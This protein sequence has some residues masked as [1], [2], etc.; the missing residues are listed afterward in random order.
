VEHDVTMFD[1]ITREGDTPETAPTGHVGGGG[2]SFSNRRL[3]SP[4]GT[5]LTIVEVA[6]EDGREHYFVS[7][8][9]KSVEG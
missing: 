1:S 9:F 6:R 3:D 8:T 2:L 4:P 5:P 7:H